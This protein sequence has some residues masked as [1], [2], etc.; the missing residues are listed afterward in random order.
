MPHRRELNVAVTG[1][2]PFMEYDFN[3]SQL[4]RDALP[5]RVTRKNQRDIRILKYGRDTRDMYEDV[6]R[7]SREIW[8]GARSLFLPEPLPGEEDESHVDIDLILHMG[9][10]ALGGDPTQFLFETV[11]RRDDYELAGDDGKLVDSDQL[12]CL[13]LPETLQTSF[14]IEAA[15]RKVHQDHPDDAGLY[16]CEFRLYSSLAEPLLTEA[17]RAKKGRVLFLHLPQAHSP[18]AIRLARDVTVSY[19]TALADDPI[20]RSTLKPEVKLGVAISEFSQAL[21]ESYRQRFAALR[22]GSPRVLNP[23]EVIRVTEELNREGAK[24]H[25]TWRPYSTRLCSFLHRIQIFASIGDVCIGDAQNLIASGEGHGI[26][27]VIDLE[28][29]HCEPDEIIRTRVR[30][31]DLG[32]GPVGPWCRGTHESYCIFRVIRVE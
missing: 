22:G 14:N 16:F 32:V 20:L 5:D 26:L 30:S 17:F 31:V 2:P 12:K 24:T 10:I 15:W 9:M 1:N 7:V 29:V 13:G 21:D 8:G 3:T 11:A 18:E 19:I 27:Q 6:R 28:T 23:A 25:R 4:V